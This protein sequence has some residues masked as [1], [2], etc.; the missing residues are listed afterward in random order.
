MI[1]AAYL[2]NLTIAAVCEVATHIATVY[3][4]ADSLTK[5]LIWLLLLLFLVKIGPWIAV[6][7]KRPLFSLR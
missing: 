6:F 1:A 4:Q 7:V 2:L 3:G 5:V